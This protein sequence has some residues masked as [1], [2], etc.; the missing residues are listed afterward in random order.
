MSYFQGSRSRRSP[1]ISEV[2]NTKNPAGE[3]FAECKLHF[4]MFIEIYFDY[5]CI[6]NK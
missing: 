4:S 6:H 5:N 2:I 3:T 1:S